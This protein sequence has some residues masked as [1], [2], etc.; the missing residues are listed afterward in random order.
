MPIYT[1]SKNE[2]SDLGPRARSPARRKI[3]LRSSISPYYLTSAVA[4]PVATNACLWRV[5]QSPRV[6]ECKSAKCKSA[7]VSSDR[8]PL[9]PQL[10]GRRLRWDLVGI[11][12]DALWPASPTYPSGGCSVL[13]C[14]ASSRPKSISQRQKKEKKGRHPL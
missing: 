10:G 2:S 7:P 11:P 1:T 12:A 5:R 4:T 13:R 14:S 8:D 9:T 3:F 6:Q